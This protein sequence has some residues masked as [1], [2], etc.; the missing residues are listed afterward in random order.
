VT[1]NEAY[2]TLGLPRDAT[3][4][5][6][7]AAYRRLVAETH[8]DRGGAAAEFIKIRAA[9]EILSAFLKQGAPEDG[10]HIPEDLRSVI[11]GIVR[12]FREH[13]R[14]VDEETARQMKVF[15]AHMSNYIGTASRSELRQFSDV[16]RNSWNATIRALFSRYNAKCGEILQSYESWYTKSTQTVFDDMYRREL[17]RFVARRRFWEIFVVVATIAGALTVVVGWTGPVSRW[18][19]TGIMRVGVV[20]SFLGYR[21]W[22][23]RRRRVRETVEPLS[24]TPFEMQEGARFR[25]ES[26]MR[27]GRRTTAALGVAGLF[28]GNAAAGGFVLPVVGAVAGMA[29]GGVFDRLLN[30]T[31]RMREGM[32]QDLRRFMVVARPQVAAYV[33]EAH[34]RLLEDV[35]GQIVT[36]YEDRVKGTVRL[37]TAGNTEPTK[38]ARRG[39]AG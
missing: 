37:L 12:D 32:Q 16:F 25:T 35:R 18:A 33:L 6:L 23:K 5:Q 3:P 13:Q 14:W 30:P 29:F 19:S 15:E 9:Y 1:L 7:K 31:G 17:L 38:E 34:E 27:R 24:V 39:A 2:R 11:D 4:A 21:W 22:C 20:I 8:P 28:I 36:N 10:I 26:T